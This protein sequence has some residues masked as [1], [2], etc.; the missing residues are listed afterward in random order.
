MAI[1]KQLCINHFDLPLEIQIMIKDYAFCDV[2]GARL[3]NMKKRFIHTIY[4]SYCSSNIQ[5]NP[6]HYNNIQGY[7]FNN[8]F[9]RFLCSFC[10]Y[11][12]NYIKSNTN[13]TSTLN[14]Y[15]SCVC[16]DIR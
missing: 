9:R 5:Y 15:T 16:E 7:C 1:K 4:H 13:P 14:R 10:K 6:S 11:C 8:Y 12:G 2:E 3:K